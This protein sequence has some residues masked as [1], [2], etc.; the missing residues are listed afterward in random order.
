MKMFLTRLGFNSK[1]VITGDITQVDLPASRTSGLIEV[2]TVLQGVD[3]I[4]FVY[5]DDRDVVRHDLVSSIVRA[6]DRVQKSPPG[7]NDRTP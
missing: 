7:G 3:G 6:Y 2:Q 4:R 5:F 1:M